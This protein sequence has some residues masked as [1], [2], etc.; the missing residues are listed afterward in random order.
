MVATHSSIDGPLMVEVWKRGFD[1]I[2]RLVARHF[3]QD[4]AGLAALQVAAPRF[5]IVK[6]ATKWMAASLPETVVT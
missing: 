3:L 5:L 4:R 1:G 2:D 6:D